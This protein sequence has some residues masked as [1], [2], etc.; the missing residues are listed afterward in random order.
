MLTQSRLKELLH[1]SPETGDF[2]WLVQRGRVKIGDIAGSLH[3]TGYRITQIAEKEYSAHRLA[4]FY[5]TG[6]WPADQVDHKNG[7]RHD[8]RWDNLRQA[9]HA[10]NHQNGAVRSNN[11][12]GFM[13]VSWNVKRRKWQA[14]ITFARRIK[15]LGRFTTPEDAYA[16]YLAAKANL[17]PFQPVPRDAACL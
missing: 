14:H 5:M 6:A 3:W 7:V 1:Y 4:F 2:T 15:F 10:E 11:K 9:T 16:A 12:S 8:N 17:H 13:G